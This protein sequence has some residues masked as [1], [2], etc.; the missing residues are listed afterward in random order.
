MFGGRGRGRGSGPCR[1][2]KAGLS[3]PSAGPEAPRLAAPKLPLPHHHVPRSFP[4]VTAVNLH[5]GPILQKQTLSPEE[6]NPHPSLPPG[7][8]LLSPSP[9]AAPDPGSQGQ[10]PPHLP[11]PGGQAR[12]PLLTAARIQRSWQK[13]VARCSRVQGG[14]APRERRG[15]ESRAR[16]RALQGGSCGRRTDPGAQG[17]TRGCWKD[18]GCWGRVPRARAQTTVCGA[19]A[20]AALGVRAADPHWS[21]GG[22]GAW[23]GGGRQGRGHGRAGTRCVAHVAALPW[24]S[25]LLQPPRGPAGAASPAPQPAE[26][27]ASGP[28]GWEGPGTDPPRDS[29][30]LP[31]APHLTILHSW[32]P[33]SVFKSFPKSD[34][35]SSLVLL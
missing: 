1:G 10:P 29:Q 18:P 7:S 11:A 5:D 13:L 12:Q 15:A 3:P 22:A 23:V 6:P 20:A 24:Q 14:R 2:R 21:R 4:I 28:I 9:F 25:P 30:L 34:R 31:C 33:R 35:M 19:G 17:G 26:Y 32:L 16:R 8:S 27:T